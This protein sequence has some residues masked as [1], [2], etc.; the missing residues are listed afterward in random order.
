MIRFTCGERKIYS[1]IKKYQ[2]IMN[3]I[4]CKKFVLVFKFLLTD[5]IVKSSLF[6]VKNS[7]IFF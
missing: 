3:M 7:L 1:T 2:I 5:F 6:I 4:I